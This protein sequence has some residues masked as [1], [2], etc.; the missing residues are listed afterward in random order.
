MT[1]AAIYVRVSSKKQ[2]AEERTSLADQ[3]K[4]CRAYAARESWPVV[5]VG[6]DTQTGFETM[7]QRPAL[8]EVRD[9]IQ[10][11]GADV[12]IVWRFD[13]AARDQVDLLVLNREVRSAGARLVVVCSPFA[14]W[15][16]RLSGRD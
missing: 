9:L 3:E 12:L 2:A 4:E 16:R 7:D 14:A 10:S 5:V 1:T 15:R 13:R 6:R 8:Q 11:S